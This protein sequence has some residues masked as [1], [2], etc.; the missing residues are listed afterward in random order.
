MFD[1]IWF[2]YKARIRAQERLAQND[3]HSQALL[4]WYAV[5]GT[6]LA[7]ISLQYPKFLGDNTNLTSAVF[8]V[9]ILAVSMLVTNRDFRGRSLEM[10]RN[11]LAIH[12]L[13]QQASKQSESGEAPAQTEAAYHTLVSAVENHAAIDDKY[14]RVF[15]NGSL[16]TRNPTMGEKFDVY[17][18]LACRTV[19]LTVLYLAPFAVFLLLS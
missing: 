9:A 15:H 4:V 11:Y 17:T 2:T 10:R 12:N 16:K 8:S 1:H 13:Y 5:I 14:F 18:Y 19:F 6:C 7:I 3:L